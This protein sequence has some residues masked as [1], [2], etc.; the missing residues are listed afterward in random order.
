[1]GKRDTYPFW[2]TLF[3]IQE[4]EDSSAKSKKLNKAKR[5]KK[6]APEFQFNDKDYSKEDDFTQDSLRNLGKK[7]FLHLSRVGLSFAFFSLTL[8]MKI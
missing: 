6:K 8:V 3:I 5:K 4:Q 1:M 7:I 2:V